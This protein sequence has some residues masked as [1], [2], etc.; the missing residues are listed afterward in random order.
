MDRLKGL[1]G[2]RRMGRVTNSRI[3]EMNGVMKGVQERIDESVF[4]LFGY[5]QRMGNDRIAKRVYV[6][7]YVGNGLVNR[8][9]KA[10][11]KY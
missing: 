11:G 9:K 10:Y 2:I 1:L 8:P 6:R 7:E 4:R 5:I 3:R